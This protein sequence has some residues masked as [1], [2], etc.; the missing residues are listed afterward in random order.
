MAIEFRPPLPTEVPQLQELFEEA[1]EEE[2]FAD[3]FFR[4]GFSPERCLVAVEGSVLGML[5]WF[6]CTL[7]KQHIAY[8]YAIAV[9]E[10]HRGRGI[11]T[12]L[13]RF[14]I[15]YLQH[16]S[17]I[18]LVPAEADLFEY[19]KR[20]GFSVVSTMIHIWA[21]AGEPIAIRALSP[22]AFAAR[23]KELLPPKGI[24][25]GEPM[26]SLLH[27]YAKFYAGPNC[28]AVVSG[29]QVLEFLGDPAEL[30]GL[31]AALGLGAAEVRMPGPGHPFAMGLGENCYFGLAL[32]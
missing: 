26:L 32:D 7:E 3:A 23:R 28:L 6:D 14:S 18:L 27:S 19:Y 10:S 29:G 30:P 4:L 9:R 15:G 2:E 20:L 17:E 5:H 24:V 1:F 25:Q 21:L 11:G 8:L 16:C 12:E 22:A 13:I 31:L